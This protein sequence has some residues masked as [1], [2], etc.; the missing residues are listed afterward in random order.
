MISKNDIDILFLVETDIDM[1]YM[2]DEF[3][4]TVFKMYLSDSKDKKAKKY[5]NR[6]GCF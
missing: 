3:E 4:I 2:E 6:K 1:E 5:R